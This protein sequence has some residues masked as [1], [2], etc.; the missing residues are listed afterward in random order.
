M[1]V[2]A[3][4][5]LVVRTTAPVVELMSRAIVECDGPFCCASA[6]YAFAM[7]HP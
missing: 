6:L 1:N 7:P 2:P 3:A 5:T 4:F